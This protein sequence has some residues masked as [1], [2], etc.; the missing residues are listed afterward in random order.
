MNNGLNDI[1][2]ALLLEGDVSDI[3]LERDE[4]EDEIQ[5]L[6]HA[7][8][9]CIDHQI[10]AREVGMAFEVVVSHEVFKIHI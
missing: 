6:Y 9:G 4:E 7:E 1:E 2:I 5:D 3:E 10:L 8:E